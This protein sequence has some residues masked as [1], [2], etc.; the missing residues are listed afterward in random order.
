MPNSDA[1]GLFSLLRDVTSL[2]VLE[3]LVRKPPRRISTR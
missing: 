1:T 2:K 3:D